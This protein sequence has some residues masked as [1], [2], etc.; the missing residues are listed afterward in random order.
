MSNPGQ[1]I[2][3]YGS[4]AYGSAPIESLQLGYYLSLVTS[5]H[6]NSPK[7]IAF[8]TVLLKKFQDISQCLTAMD[9]AFDVDNAVGPQLDLVGAIV[10]ANR[11]VGFQPTGGV[12]PVLD[13]AT[14]RILIKAQA[15]QNTWNGKIDSLQP[16]WETLFPGGEIV[17]GDL[18]NMSAVIFITGTFTSIELDLIRNGY[19]V[20]R[21]E[22]VQ[23][24]DQFGPFPLFGF[25]S[26]NPTLIAGFG[27]GK[28]TES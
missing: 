28:F 25:G 7:F 24:F 20:P 11:T 21:P 8:L 6:R 17:I 5:E 14:Y 9:T 16:I 22:G 13:D 27:V 4:G 26:L 15:A 23:Y 3:S 10:G 1:P 12:S 18:Q 2:Q 19:I